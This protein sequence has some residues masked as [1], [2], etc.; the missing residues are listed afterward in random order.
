MKIK[1]LIF[2]LLFTYKAFSQSPISDMNIYEGKKLEAS[3]KLMEKTMKLF[4]SILKKYPNIE[5]SNLN[6]DSLKEF[7]YLNHLLK[8]DSIYFEGLRDSLKIL[9]LDTTNTYSC[10]IKI[11]ESD[12]STNYNNDMEHRASFLLFN[13]TKK[14]VK[15]IGFRFLGVKKDT[16][17]EVFFDNSYFENFYENEYDISISSMSRKNLRFRYYCK[18]IAK[19]EKYWIYEVTFADGKKWKLNSYFDV[20]KK[21]K[22]SK[23]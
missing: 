22:K 6:L 2:L 21:K 11:M 4:D 7:K 1:N 18:N 8:Q 15:K 13:N 19:I 16:T 23:K 14:Y 9:L 17:E 20:P 3:F 10:P 12:F 5:T